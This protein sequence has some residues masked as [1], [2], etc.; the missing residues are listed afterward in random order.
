MNEE[1]TARQIGN[2][3]GEEFKVKVSGGLPPEVLKELNKVDNLH[4]ALSVLTTLAMIGG[5]VA[6]V[7]TW[8]SVW[9]IVPALIIMASRHHSF[10]ILSHDA[11]HYRLFG[12]RLLNEIVG[13]CCGYVIGVSMCTYRVVHRLHH[14]HLYEKIDPDIPLMGG[15]PRGKAYLLKKL[16]KDLT[17]RTAH[18]NY[19]YFFGAPSI[20]DET[21]KAVIPLEDTSPRL[22]QQA[23]LD[24]WIMIV[25]QIAML[26]I[27]I[28]TGYWMEYLI[29]WVL[30]GLT[31]FQVILRLRAVLEH[32][33]PEDQTNVR[34]AARTNI[35]PLWL[36]W[37]L[38]PHSV[39]YHL[40]H[41]LYPAIPHYKLAAAHQALKDHDLLQGAEIRPVFD[42]FGRVF[43]NPA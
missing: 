37:I 26:S 10:A 18:M 20:N 28:L 15:Y 12:N 19:G 1:S 41:H 29:L 3:Q 43:A 38:F 14:N 24:R 9:T 32:G 7:M 22:R 39:N 23:L 17:F 5:T 8:W 27:S 36:S 40:E 2:A 33:A 35:C 13:R 6:V 31:L 25:V 4:G 21:G 11:V 30:P 34:K 16:F 42:T